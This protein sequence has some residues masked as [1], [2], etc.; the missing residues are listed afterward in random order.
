MDGENGWV[1]R[2]DWLDEMRSAI[3]RFLATDESTLNEMR[4]KAQ[5]S[6]AELTPQWAADKILSVVEFV[7]SRP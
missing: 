6:V 3:S 7:R 2:A 1:F 4:E 5:T